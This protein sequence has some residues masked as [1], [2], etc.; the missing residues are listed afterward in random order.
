MVVKLIAYADTRDEAFAKLR[1]ALAEFEMDGIAS[2][3]AFLS[4][5]LDDPV[6]MRGE[7]TT[8]YIMTTF[9]LEFQQQHVQEVS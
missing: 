5:L 9:L 1:E 2:N 6:V 8:N 4:A 7:A 3:Q